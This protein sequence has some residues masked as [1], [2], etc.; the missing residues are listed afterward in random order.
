MNK[1]SILSILAIIIILITGL[2]TLSGCSPK[3]P[4]IDNSI[5]NQVLQNIIANNPELEEHIVEIDK[6]EITNEHLLLAADYLKLTADFSIISTGASHRGS[7]LMQK[8]P[9]AEHSTMAPRSC[10]VPVSI[11]T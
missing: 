4:T 6:V 2:F 5:K 3:E 9:S 8:V 10:T 1:K 7:F 11:S